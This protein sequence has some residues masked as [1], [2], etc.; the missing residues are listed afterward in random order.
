MDKVVVQKFWFTDIENLSVENQ[1]K[2]IAEVIRSE[3]GMERK[4][5]DDI[6]IAALVDYIRRNK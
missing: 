5:R 1:D 2:I 3:L 6:V 4:Y